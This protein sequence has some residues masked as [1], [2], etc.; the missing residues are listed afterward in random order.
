M[1]IVIALTS[2]E[3]VLFVSKAHIRSQKGDG[4]SDG[5]GIFIKDIEIF[6]YVTSKIKL[7]AMSWTHVDLDEDL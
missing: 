2:A 4:L 5:I 6:N 7:S 3:N 1:K